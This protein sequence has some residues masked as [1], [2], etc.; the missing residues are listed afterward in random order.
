M[1]STKGSKDTGDRAPCGD[2]GRTK[3][4][5]EAV[6]ELRGHGSK[7]LG[8]QTLAQFVARGR[9]PLGKIER[10]DRN[11]LIASACIMAVF[12]T[13]PLYLS[14]VTIAIGNFSTGAAG[15]FAILFVAAFFLLF[16]LRARYQKKRDG[17]K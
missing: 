2:R 9:R 16:W 12:A 10:K 5:H 17:E 6:S 8:R 1:R 14:T 4:R 11:A 3:K 13:A 7:G 15:G